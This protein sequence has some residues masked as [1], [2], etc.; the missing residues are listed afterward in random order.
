[1]ETHAEPSVCGPPRFVECDSP[2]EKGLQ[3]RRLAFSSQERESIVVVFLARQH[4]V[5][6]D[7]RLQLIGIG[8][9]V[10]IDFDP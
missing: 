1:M 8:Q 3:G 9:T 6:V 10:D 7:Q 2:S 4:A 5:F